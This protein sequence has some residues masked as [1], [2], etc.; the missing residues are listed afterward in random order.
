M[1]KEDYEFLE[2]T[3]RDLSRFLRERQEDEPWKIEERQK[4]QKRRLFYV[5]GS[6]PPAEERARELERKNFLSQPEKTPAFAE[7]P[8]RCAGP[9]ADL[10]LNR[11]ENRQFWTAKELKELPYLKDLKYRKTVDGLHQFR[12]RR[13]GINAQFTSKNYET[14]KKKARAFIAELKRKMSNAITPKHIDTVDYVARLWFDNKKTHVD[15]QTYRTYLSV[16]KNHIKPIF[17]N[18]KISA[19]LPIDLQP[20]FNDLFSR[21]GKTCENSKVIL[22][23]IFD[24]AVA[25]RICPTNP[26][27]AVIVERHVRTPGK[28]LTDEQIE[29]FKQVMLKSDAFGTAYLII[30]YSGI[31]GAELERMTF[32]WENG[33]FTVYNAKLKKSQKRSA[34]NLTRT[35]PIFPALYQIR[36]RIEK[37]DWHVPARKL[38]N[39]FCEFWTENTVKDLRHTFTTKARMS[40]V[41]NELVNLWTGHLP[42][43]NVTANVYTHFTMKYQQRK[44]KKVMIY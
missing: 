11:N 24:L 42:G 32:D 41:E 36:E 40:G 25:N 9:N 27:K 38:S 7:P 18:R 23:G 17:G 3:L 31:R 12:Y 28:A 22:S 19:I 26:M 1:T 5:V 35:V 4:A 8:R 34:S 20:F 37:N 43:T 13:D 14:A 15:L 33:T 39:S 10:Q 44:A 2:N 29:R 6:L 21:L 30:L 16:Y